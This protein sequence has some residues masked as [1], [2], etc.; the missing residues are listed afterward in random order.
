MDYA[1]GTEQGG[2]EYTAIF[3]G[4]NATAVSASAPVFAASR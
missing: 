3:A 4:S 1:P 2:S